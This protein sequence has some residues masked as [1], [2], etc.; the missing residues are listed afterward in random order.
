MRRTSIVGVLGVVCLATPGWAQNDLPP[1][2]PHPAVVSVKLAVPPPALINSHIL[3]L[4]NCR[5]NGCP[6]VADGTGDD[7]RTNHSQIAPHSGTLTA[8]LASVDFASI[9]SCMATA[10]A[11]Y[12]ITVTDVDPGPS[13]QHFEIIIA[14]RPTEIGFDANFEG[15][16]PYLCSAPGQCG[17]SYIP[18]AITFA[19][20]NA[21]PTATLMCGVGL[22][23]SAHGWTLDHSTVASSPMTYKT[24]APPLTFH[25][26]A[27]CGSDCQ[28][29]CGTSVCNSFGVLCAGQGDTGTHACMENN[30][31]TQNE[32]DI[33]LAL[34]GPAGAVAPTLAITTPTTGAG[35]QIGAAFAIN[36]T[37]SSADG[38]KEIDLYLDGN[39]AG[40]SMT[41]P[42]MFTAPKT[43]AAGPHHIEVIC[44]SNKQATTSAKVDVILGNTCAVDADCG[45]NG[46]ICYQMA[47]IAGQ[48]AAGGLGATCAG[49]G[50][51]ASGQCGNDGTQSLCVIPC[52]TTMA[53]CPT[54]FGC[55]D[56]GTGSTTGV[57]WL[58]ADSS[59][60]GCCETGHG[61]SRGSILF[62]LGFA[63]VWITRGRGRKTA[64]K[65]RS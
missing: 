57:C 31:A 19:F 11:P 22:Q 17:G 33:I 48:N 28:Y 24:Y 16:A 39:P 51:C 29:M 63:A 10:L 49:N 21:Y 1:I 3:F 6:I 34:F 32:S 23:E 18:N 30:T 27:P 46:Q 52:D 50:D 41:S 5:P 35:E 59:G 12:N 40:G 45:G 44:G 13:V 36:A 65:L 15:V 38:I 61:D 37:C 62:G 58:G 4:N 53:S 42:A 14:G 47:C 54:G 43:L 25:N 26:A 7:S 20:A 9:K 64:G 56:D 8:L 55:L 60:S 2:G